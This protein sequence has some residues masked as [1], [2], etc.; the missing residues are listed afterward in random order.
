[1]NNL[2]FYDDLD[3]DYLTSRSLK[4]NKKAVRKVQK[5]GLSN[6]GDTLIKG[7]KKAR[8]LEVH[9]GRYR[10]WV[11][12]N[13]EN[14]AENSAAEN[15]EIN[16]A[17]TPQN[18]DYSKI[19]TL[20]KSSKL[21]GNNIVVGDIVNFKPNNAYETTNDSSN[22]TTGR[23]VSIDPARTSLIRATKGEKI[24]KLANNIDIVVLLEAATTP[25][26]DPTVHQNVLQYCE[27]NNLEFLNLITKTENIN[28]DDFPDSPIYG[29]FTGANGVYQISDEF[30]EAVE[31]KTIVLAGQSGVG[32]TTLFNFL[33]GEN[34]AANNVSAK[35]GEGTHTSSS[36]CLRPVYIDMNTG[37]SSNPQENSSPKFFIIDTPG[38]RF[39]A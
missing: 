13:S 26:A 27:Q 18:T 25:I 23:I 9:R 21:G 12:E 15:F 11:L 30:Y 10:A 5:K 20:I 34:R 37:R 3:E 29:G 7:T 16:A 22:E 17:E 6:Q 35:S 4:T 36:A 33:T 31:G 24:H 2:S 1:M 19:V 8:I 32:K 38:F 28:L 39:W 14:S